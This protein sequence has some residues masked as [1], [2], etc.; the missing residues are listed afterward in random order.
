MEEVLKF[1][2]KC[3]LKISS[4]S[5]MVLTKLTYISEFHK[6]LQEFYKVYAHP[7]PRLGP[8]RM[9]GLLSVSRLLQ[10]WEPN[11]ICLRMTVSSRLTY[12]DCTLLYH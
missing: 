3:I 9:M 1:F 10:F 12:I 11:C 4:F 7:L 8:F 5:T 2:P 6:A